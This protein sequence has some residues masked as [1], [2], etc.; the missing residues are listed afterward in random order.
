MLGW[1]TGLVDL[2]ALVALPLEPLMPQE[3][4]LKVD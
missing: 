3:F 2:L 1:H 4:L